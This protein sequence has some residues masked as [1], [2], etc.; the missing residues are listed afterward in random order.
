[1]QYQVTR[2]D[3]VDTCVVRSAEQFLLG[4]GELGVGKG[5]PFV[6]IGEPGK[7]VR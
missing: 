5:A 3:Y 1:M 7:L 4:R 6:K 2:R